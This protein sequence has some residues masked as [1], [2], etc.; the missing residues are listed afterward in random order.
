MG[1]AIKVGVTLPMP[2]TP[3]GWGLGNA[4]VVWK[5]TILQYADPKMAG[6]I[7]EGL[8]IFGSA[9]CILGCSN[10]VD[11]ITLVY[12]ILYP[13]GT[14]GPWPLVHRVKY[15]VHFGNTVSPYYYHPHIVNS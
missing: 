8:A 13:A 15:F 2:D 6:L 4:Y 9:Y 10:K 5:N 3:R 7:K 12:K 1:G 14:H 11:N